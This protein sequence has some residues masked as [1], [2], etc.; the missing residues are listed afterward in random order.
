MSPSYVQDSCIFSNWSANIRRWAWQN[1]HITTHIPSDSRISHSAGKKK[2]GHPKRPRHTVSSLL[3]N[4]H[5]LLRVSSFARWPLSLHFF[6]PD[7]YKAWLKWCKSA[8][9]PIQTTIAIIQDFPPPSS[10]KDPPISA[11]ERSPRSNVLYWQ[12]MRHYFEIIQ[13]SLIFEFGK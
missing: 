5:L 10:D 1:P 3:S 13:C 4:L 8:A 11:D 12:P 6:S 2:S 7:V 9:E